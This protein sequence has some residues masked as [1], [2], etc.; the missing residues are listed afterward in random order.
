MGQ[1][2][3]V[4]LSHRTEEEPGWELMCLDQPSQSIGAS[5]GP[6]GLLG[7][8]VPDLWVVPGPPGASSLREPEPDMGHFRSREVRGDPGLGASREAAGEA[9]LAEALED[10]KELSRQASGEGK[11]EKVSAEWHLGPPPSAFEWG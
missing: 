4:P 2:Q 6:R 5:T 8:C 10:K 3:A 11:L 7:P 9:W 1:G